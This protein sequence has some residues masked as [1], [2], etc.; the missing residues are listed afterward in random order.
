M[1]LLRVESRVDTPKTDRD[2]ET[3][4]DTEGS[5]PQVV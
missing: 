5:L 2:A 3:M 1:D 4:S